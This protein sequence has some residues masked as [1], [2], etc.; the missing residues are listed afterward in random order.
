VDVALRGFEVGVAIVFGVCVWT[1]MVTGD[2][3]GGAR[4]KICRDVCW[5]RRL[6]S[7]WVGEGSFRMGRIGA[8]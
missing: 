1:G 7:G 3:G 4:W 6:S 2:G 8:N 5:D